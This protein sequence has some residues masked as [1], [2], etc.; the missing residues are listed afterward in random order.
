MT[1]FERRDLADRAARP[2]T[3]LAAGLLA[4]LLVMVLPESWTQG[5]KDAVRGVL[6]PGLIAVGAMRKPAGELIS[7][8]GRHF[9][10]A[11]RLAAAQK[12]LAALRQENERLKT[13]ITALRIEAGAG[14]AMGS[15]DQKQL[16]GVECVEAHVLGQQALAF[17]GRNHFLDVGVKQAV[18]PDDLVVQ[19][20]PGL[21]DRGK[22]SPV[23]AGQ[24]VVHESKV[25]GK[26]VEVGRFIS[27]VRAL[28]EPGYR[29]VVQL[30]GGDSGYP[31]GPLG[32]L[33][34]TGEALVR[35]RLIEVTEPVSIGDAVYT[36]ADKG[37]LSRPLLYGHI[38][39]V[40]R[41]VGATHWDLWMQPAVDPQRLRRVAVLTTV[42]SASR[43]ASEGDNT[44]N[45]R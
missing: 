30:S 22:N 25:W 19:A 34:G 8:A 44:E 12:E 43:L 18:E 29:D 37:V 16:L 9:R 36:A 1:T 28:T 39:R 41:P 2:G 35:I 13:A 7:A 21:I 20:M 11:D 27:T 23:A 4:S 6:R 38:V 40:A 15:V 24:L 26:I 42:L 14:T 5:G 17:L 3:A 33:E 31:S 45:R 32:I 10:T